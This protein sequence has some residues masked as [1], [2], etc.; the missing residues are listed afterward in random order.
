MWGRDVASRV[1]ARLGAGLTGDAVD[2]DV[3]DGRLVGW[4]PAFGGRLV[5]AV[6]AT[7]PVQMATVRPGM[8]PVPEPREATDLPADEVVVPASGRVRY[9]DAM[10]EDDVDTLQVA[11]AVVGVGTGVKPD[12]Y[13]ELDPLLAVLEA[14]IGATRKVTDKG[15]LPRARQIGITGRSISPLLYVAVGLSGKFNHM[16]GELPRVATIHVLDE[17]RR[18]V[19]VLLREPGLP[20]VRGLEDVGIRRDHFVAHR[21]LQMAD[22]GVRL[23]EG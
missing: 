10:R 17:L 22:A 2:L 9:L 4:K 23:S 15:W 3:R 13:A 19:L 18:L 5:A 20:D 7:S 14:E 16:V 12:E 11:G 21:L 1:A 8:L 6:T